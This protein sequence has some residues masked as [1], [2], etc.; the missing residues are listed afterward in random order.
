[1]YACRR[2][3][4][5]NGGRGIPDMSKHRRSGIDGMRLVK[6]SRAPH[7]LR[8]AIQERSVQNPSG[9]TLDFPGLVP[10][11]AEQPG[12]TMTLAL[13][14]HSHDKGHEPGDS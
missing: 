2:H 11:V 12:K 5:I 9:L 14:T 6:P 8:I 1:M 4:V 3:E 7:G 13:V 10:G